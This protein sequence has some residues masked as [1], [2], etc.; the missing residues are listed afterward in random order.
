MHLQDD[1]NFP[2][3]PDAEAESVSLALSHRGS[4]SIAQKSVFFLRQSQQSHGPWQTLLTCPAPFVFPTGN[5]RLLIGG[6][7]WKR[8]SP[9]SQP[10]NV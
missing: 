9:H 6:S 1:E 7:G 10:G 5:R 4:V 3:C 8:E 2:L